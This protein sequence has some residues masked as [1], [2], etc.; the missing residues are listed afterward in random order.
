MFTSEELIA[1][2]DPYTDEEKVFLD[3]YQQ[4]LEVRKRLLSGEIADSRIEQLGIWLHEN[5]L[6]T[7]FCIP[8]DYPKIFYELDANVRVSRHQ[9]Y[10]PMVGHRHS[11]FEIIYVLRGECTNIIEGNP[12][13]M[14]ERDICIMTPDV[15]HAMNVFSDSLIINFL[16]RKT[17]FKETFF[18]FLSEDNI[19]SDF[20]MRIFYKQDSDT[21]LLFHT[22]GNE[23]LQ[24][25]LEY[26]I[27]ED[28]FEKDANGP[29]KDYLLMSAF[30]YMLRD[31][32]SDVEFLG[33]SAFD[34]TKIIQI[35]RYIVEHYK[36]ATLKETAA[37][38]GYVPNYLSNLIKAS[39]GNTFSSIIKATRI[40]KACKLLTGTVMPIFDIYEQAGYSSLEHF[41][42]I[43]KEVKGVTPLEYR[44][45]AKN[46]GQNHMGEEI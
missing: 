23:R 42:R 11:F 19:I 16:I 40:D 41:Y 35:L 31:S 13:V 32:S 27:W 39:T 3:I 26:I 10:S 34:N 29:L 6:E 37:V 17:T 24:R 4:R 28:L 12:I 46:N 9:R 33:N 5:T 43:F 38:F 22:L 25:L 44:R 8:E 15:S 21:C 7:L 30:C 1:R 2:L 20:F 36:T 14:K 45:Q 18:R